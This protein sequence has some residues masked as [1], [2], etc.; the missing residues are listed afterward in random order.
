M[1]GDDRTP[2]VAFLQPP[3]STPSSPSLTPEQQEQ[4]RQPSQQSFQLQPGSGSLSAYLSPT[5]YVQSHQTSASL[6]PSRSTS[7]SSSVASLSLSRE[8]SPQP[9]SLKEPTPTNDHH[10]PAA[11]GGGSM[12]ISSRI[13]STGSQ[14]ISPVNEVRKRTGRGVPHRP[15][16]LNLD[17]TTPTESSSTLLTPQIPH[18]SPGVK[19]PPSDLKV[20]PPLLSPSACGAESDP[21]QSTSVPPTGV[22]IPESSNSRP[23]VST[24]KGPKG[25]KGRGT[26]FPT[27]HIRTD[28][29]LGSDSTR[30]A[31][32]GPFTS[33]ANTTSHTSGITFDTSNSGNSNA[34]VATAATT[35]I[36]HPTHH[37][38]QAN[39]N[40]K[41]PK[42]VISKWQ[43]ELERLL[44]K[45]QR[46]KRAPSNLTWYASLSTQS[47]LS[48]M[49]VGSQS[50]GRRRSS[51][52]RLEQE[53]EE[54]ESLCFDKDKAPKWVTDSFNDEG[55]FFS[56]DT[57]DVT[58]SLRDFLIRAAEGG[59]D[60]SELKEEVQEI[61]HKSMFH[62]KRNRSASPSASPR[63]ASPVLGPSV[64]ASPSSHDSPTSSHRGSRSSFEFDAYSH[65]PVGRPLEEESSCRL[66]DYLIAIMSD[67]ISY[68]CR[69]KVQHP[70]P[71]RPEWALHSIVLDILTYLSKALAH[72]H[73]AMYDLGLTALSAFPIFKNHS[74][75]RLLS[76]MTDIIIPSFIQSRQ[77]TIS[78]SLAASSLSPLRL[79]PLP[80]TPTQQEH[81]ASATSPSEIRVNNQTFAIQ[82]HSP[83]DEKGL[84]SVPRVG[85]PSLGSPR[86]PS[87]RSSSTSFSRTGPLIPQIQDSVEEHTASLISMTLVAALRQISLSKS[88]LPVIK[89][90]QESVGQLLRIKP[91]LSSDL[92]EAV[93]LVENEQV[94]YR[95]L[96]ILSWIARPSLGHHILSENRPTLDYEVILAT[97]RAKQDLPTTLPGMTII[98]NRT[99]TFKS[100][101]TSSFR[102]G[103]LD[104]DSV[105]RTDEIGPRSNTI[106]SGR[107]RTMLPYR[108]PLP[109]KATA[110]SESL[111]PH[112]QHTSTHEQTHLGVASHGPGFNFLVEHEIYPYLF[113]APE[114]PEDTAAS[115]KCTCERCDQVLKGYGLYCYHCR[116]SIHLECFYSLKKF[117]GMEY[118]L[119]GHAFD[120]VSRS[121]RNQLLYPE[122]SNRVYE[123]KTSR[124]FRLRAGHHL[125]LV[126]LFSTCLCTACRLPLWGH[127][128]QAYRC[129]DCSQLMHLDCAG[130]VEKCGE[131]ST[132]KLSPGESASSDATVTSRISLMDLR[133]SFVEHYWHLYSTWESVKPMSS[134][135][136]LS[137]SSPA[138]VNSAQSKDRWSYE[139]ASCNASILTLQLELL[140][141]GISRDE[142]QVLEWTEDTS[143]PNSRQNRP[144][145]EAMLSSE[146][147][148]VALQ[149]HFTEL[150]QKLQPLDLISAAAGSSSAVQSHFLLDFMGDSK[151][152]LFLLFTEHYWH[153]LAAVTKTLICEASLGNA[154]SE[155]LEDEMF[156]AKEEDGKLAA[157]ALRSVPHLS[158]ASLLRFCIR[159][160]G[161]QNAW[162]MQQI[163][164]EW[165]KL[166]LL[167]RLDGE[168]CLFEPIPESDQ[169]STSSIHQT[170]DDNG[171]VSGVN[172]VG[173][174]GVSS[175]SNRTSNPEGKP[176]VP[177]IEVPVNVDS[178]P[179]PILTR[180]TEF[181]HDSN[182]SLAAG[183]TLIKDIVEQKRGSP[184]IYRSAPCLFPLA[185]A[186]DPTPEVES[187]IQAVWRC[188]AS[189]DLSL[190]ELGFM[191]LTRQCWPDGFMSDYTVE[192]L[193]GGVFY[194]LLM[195]DEQLFVIHGR[196]TSRGK[197]IPGIRHGL[198]DQ[199]TRKRILLNMSINGGAHENEGSNS[200]GATA[201]NTNASSWGQYPVPLASAASGTGGSHSSLFGEVGAYVKTRKLMVKRFALPWLKRVLE[202]DEDRYL[203]AAYRQIRIL[204]REMAPQDD[205][206]NDLVED[207]QRFQYA[208]AERYLDSITKLRHAGF[209]F[210]LFPKILSFWLKYVEGLSEGMD[211]G[212]NKG[213]KSLNRLFLKANQ[214]VN[215]SRSGSGVGS[216]STINTGG[217]VDSGS[218]SPTPTSSAWSENEWR[219]RLK[220]KLYGNKAHETQHCQSPL[221]TVTTTSDPGLGESGQSSLVGV[222]SGSS[223]TAGSGSN[224]GT[225]VSAIATDSASLGDFGES[226][227]S[228]LRTILDLSADVSVY[229][230]TVGKGHL[231]GGPQAPSKEEGLQTAIYW[232]GLMVQSN[233]PVPIQAFKDCCERMIDL[234]QLPLPEQQTIN[235]HGS[236]HIA[237][238]E[239]TQEGALASKPDTRFLS[240]ANRL[241][242]ACW[243]CIV[244]ASDSTN[245]ISQSGA[246]HVVD[247]VL[248]TNQVAITTTL[249]HP[250]G[251]DVDQEL[252]KSIQSLLK[253]SLVILMYSFGCPVQ[254]ILSHEIVPAPPLSKSSIR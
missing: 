139:E 248:S 123:D 4:A 236:G 141:A 183:S 32:S 181:L 171:N 251:Y 1:D 180:S 92:L 98:G 189:V 19:G 158:L 77:S 115:R 223:S 121:P 184:V 74:L 103:S 72:D 226:P 97:H 73:K 101:A 174:N 210:T 150:T 245:Q 38:Q 148:L 31:Q 89:Q 8:A 93:A 254:V 83:T 212:S 96:D 233:V 249:D 122:D 24:S 9:Y 220:S 192:R 175:S 80:L 129:R 13:G 151:P 227:L 55:S 250:L 112:S 85:R 39:G 113:S 90:L 231:A 218:G 99:S 209:L 144:P 35:A 243:E 48:G 34:G 246:S 204:E 54:T 52:G 81:G 168:L 125:Q 167:E 22:L 172:I 3:T 202:L 65:H 214:A 230:S 153:H 154:T 221:A 161:F 100:D 216:N 94:T 15:K 237:G 137:V 29:T 199:I 23:V 11:G 56:D 50:G 120:Y 124:I 241:L 69:Y 207:H 235:A 190:N 75:V 187:L 165:V 42:K 136:G 196:Y 5:D 198:E 46:R 68:D 110:G 232:L 143:R 49:P 2:H 163:L 203:E 91:N 88:P 191:L 118:S 201:T 222:G 170:G 197:R 14:I 229:A 238:L 138:S 33:T 10:E 152:D 173:E 131:S 179:V 225:G 211:R 20:I 119:A 116:S 155:F 132:G 128:H 71:S 178:M 36:T 66:L 51:S 177:R 21:G 95:A 169:D 239:A 25:P 205:L 6:S 84:L 44:K 156:S 59:W 135:G 41:A 58:I 16:P 104:E 253:Y 213:F 108:N 219:Q 185:T 127:H 26:K 107:I 27:L 166:G 217:A 176:G 234:S 70:R 12:T 17:H 114:C 186:I 133:K 182:A 134:P 18:P 7:P 28:L 106:G 130:V 78:P 149:K 195:E 64:P 111:L 117:A 82:V 157:S 63:I 37:Q 105:P 194:W 79:S 193:L 61:G 244:L 164:Q 109:R 242:R 102:R 43:K 87:S 142:I 145:Q 208:Q 86:I 215:S 47:Y 53:S 228:S 188:L 159:R 76:I 146:F 45:I 162:T 206:E 160:L 252:L 240:Q 67:I 140:K 200:S 57:I 40:I 224:V 62:P 147:E 30:R 126:N 247:A 60:I